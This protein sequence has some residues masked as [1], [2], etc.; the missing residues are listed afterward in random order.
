MRALRLTAY[1]R[2]A[3]GKPQGDKRRNGGHSFMV[4][5]SAWAAKKV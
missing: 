5:R 3:G 1:W 4:L 2:V